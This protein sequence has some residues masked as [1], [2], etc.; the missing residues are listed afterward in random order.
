MKKLTKVQK[1]E[2]LKNEFA[3]IDATSSQALY[4][5]CMDLGFSHLVYNAVKKEL[6]LKTEEKKVCP[7]KAF[8]EAYN[9]IKAGSKDADDLIGLKKAVELLE[10]AIAGGLDFKYTG[11]LA[12]AKRTVEF[13][14][15]KIHNREEFVEKKVALYE[16]GAISQD[17]LFEILH[18]YTTS[19][20]GVLKY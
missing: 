10:E 16:A 5:L 12:S 19:T 2:I 18:A 11:A 9:E 1:V 20:V 3:K 15:V 6:N 14:A 4:K 13:F 7:V 17:R 8:F